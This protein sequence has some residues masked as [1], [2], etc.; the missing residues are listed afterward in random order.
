MTGPWPLPR[1]A[2]PSRGETIRADILL[3]LCGPV[4]L[5][6]ETTERS[7][8]GGQEIRGRKG[9]F[10]DLRPIASR[11]SSV[12]SCLRDR[13]LVFPSEYFHARYPCFVCFAKRQ[14]SKSQRRQQRQL[15]VLS[16]TVLKNKTQLR[17]SGTEEARQELPKEGRL[18]SVHRQSSC[19]EPYQTSESNILSWLYAGHSFLKPHCKGQVEKSVNKTVPDFRRSTKFSAPFSLNHF[20]AFS[21]TALSAPCRRNAQRGRSAISIIWLRTAILFRGPA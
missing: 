5:A 19:S 8:R 1:S 18:S 3:S 14:V 21:F 4:D 12:M 7:R 11:N 2:H 20:A 6:C 17:S 15:C 9:L 13:F 10:A 16:S